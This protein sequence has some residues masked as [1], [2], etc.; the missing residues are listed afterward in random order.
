M[1]GDNYSE[2][3]VFI[4]ENSQDADREQLMINIVRMFGS[5]KRTC[6]RNCF[7]IVSKDMHQNLCRLMVSEM[8][9]I[10][11][12]PLGYW[13]SVGMRIFSRNLPR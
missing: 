3:I 6:F 12:D 9:W 4:P 8:E 10:L 11:I 5:R 7:A 2:V 13:H 1:D